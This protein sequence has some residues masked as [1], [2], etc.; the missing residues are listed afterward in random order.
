MLC[1]EFVLQ[2]GSEQACQMER[3]VRP[4]GIAT[5]SSFKLWWE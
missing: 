4:I 5:L 2:K 1:A 3:Y